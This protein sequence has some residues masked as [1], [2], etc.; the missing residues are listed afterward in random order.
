MAK[1]L[2]AKVK[3]K[4]ARSYVKVPKPIPNS[5]KILRAIEYGEQ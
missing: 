3:K 2:K 5:I 4:R 1:G